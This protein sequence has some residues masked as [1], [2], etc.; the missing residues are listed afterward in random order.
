MRIG[1]AGHVALMGRRGTNIGFVRKVEGKE[2]TRK[3]KL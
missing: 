3:P 2:T 1:W